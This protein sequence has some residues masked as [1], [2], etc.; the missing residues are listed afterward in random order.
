MASLHFSLRK[1]GYLFLGSSENLSDLAP[2]F[3]VINDRNRIYKKRNS[4]R[5]PIGSAPPINNTSSTNKQSIPAVSRL[6]RNYR[7]TNTISS[8]TNFANET[9]ITQY[10]PPCILLNDEHEALHVYGNVSRYIR[11][12]PPGRISIKINDMVN[13]DISIAVSSAIHR[14]KQSEEEVYYTD[15]ITVSGDE[16]VEINL[17]VRYIKEHEIENSPGYFWL[18][19]EEA[20]VK[21]GNQP[22]TTVSFNASEQSR[23]RIADLENELKKSKEHLQVTVEELETTNEELQSANEELMSAN[24]EL[25]STNEE[26]Q[27]VNEELY[28]VN[29]EYQDKITEISQ[30]NNDLDQVLGLSKIGIIFLDENMLIRRYTHA[31]SEYINLMETDVNRPLYHI[32]KNIQYDSM[33]H[34]VS[35]VFSKGVP[36]EKDIIIADKRVLRVA[37]NPY[38][39]ADSARS[40]GVAITFADISKAKYTEKGMSVAYNQLKNSIHNALEVLDTE[41]FLKSVNILI[42]DNNSK[43]SELLETNLNDINDFA[44]NIHKAESVSTAIKTISQG[45]ID[46]C[47][48]DYQLGNETAIDMIEA[49]RINEIKTPVIV[50]TRNEDSELNALLLSHGALD[51]IG[52]NDLSSQLLAR[53][54]RYAI[55]RQQI[56]NEINAAIYKASTNQELVN[57]E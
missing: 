14:A 29:S 28:T 4:V 44:C 8:V 43:E 23:Q 27:S 45:D 54:I 20:N 38:N 31:A 6:M 19:F 2:H 39:Y 35:D 3:E 57:E 53:S 16:A 21:G 48:V 18:I 11:H 32:S 47:L 30:I 17:R 22:K 10:A 26:L 37:I 42:V 9:L 5:I 52:K 7:G 55:R 15:I 40:K 46:I 34:D 41:S 24:E 51:L 1:N 36:K 13:E 49:F 56:D 12:L 25:Q 33:L 50:F